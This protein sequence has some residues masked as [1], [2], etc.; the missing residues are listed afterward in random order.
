MITELELKALTHNDIGT[1]AKPKRLRDGGG[2]VGQVGQDRAGRLVVSFSYQFRA[3]IPS[4]NK[5]GITSIAVGQWPKST[6]KAI[7]KQRDIYRLEVNE[8]RNPVALKQAIALTGKAQTAEIKAQAKKRLIAIDEANARMTVKDLFERWE[9]LALCKRKDKGAEI[10]RMFDKDV[11]SEMGAMA[12]ED[13]KKRHIVAMLDKVSERGVGRM[14]NLMLAQ[15]RQMFR[16]ALDREWI[17]AD[18]TAMLKKEN[19]GGK[20]VE[21][22]RVL[23]ESEITALRNKLPLAKLTP[24]TECAIWLMLSTCCRVGELSK[25]KWSDIN[26]EK[27]HWLIPASD[28]KNGREHLIALSPFAFEQILA[29]KM[30]QSSPTWIFPVTKQVGKAPKEHLHEKS[31][32]KQIRDRQ[33]LEPLKKRTKAVGVLLLSGGEWT[34]HDLR[35]TGAT[36]MG[37]LG[38]DGDVIERC[39]NH[40]EPNRMKRIYQRQRTEEAKTQ[41]WALLGERLD[42][43]CNA[44][45]SK[46]VT[47][48]AA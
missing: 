14:V 17:E 24:Q 22:D 19:F 8:G 3:F 46:V 39:L 10:R 9:S 35:R 23:S 30:I 44:D 43:L 18:P 12:V 11:I 20:D 4:K 40:V 16:F 42:M 37:E 32:S 1:K 26:W 33:R 27:K 29:L 47:L 21:R 41:A 6:L 13:V 48:N 31:F 15:V 2:L 36:L 28:T 34:P 38:V 7:R 45:M 5:E 25:A